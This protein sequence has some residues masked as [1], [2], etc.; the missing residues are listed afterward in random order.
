MKIR[1]SNCHECPFQ[2]DS[3]CGLAFFLKNDSLDITNYSNSVPKNCP[4]KKVNVTVEIEKKIKVPVNC[5]CPSM[6][7]KVKCGFECYD[8]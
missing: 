5:E 8:M 2:E 1:V 4:I 6:T 3:H 7:E